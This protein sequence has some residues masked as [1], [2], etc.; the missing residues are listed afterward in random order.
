MN[1]RVR[2]GC[3]PS[4]SQSCPP[5]DTAST[6]RRCCGS[7]STMS[8]WASIWT[9]PSALAPIA[10]DMPDPRAPSTFT[11]TSQVTGGDPMS[12]DEGGH[13][14][15][16]ALS[17]KESNMP[18]SLTGILFVDASATSATQD[19][20]LDN[21]YQSIQAA[22]NAVPV[23]A[24]VADSIKEWMTLIAPGDY[25]EDVTITG[26]VRLALIGL[27]AFRLGR[28]TVAGDPQTNIVAVAGSE[29]RNLVW[30]YDN[31]QVIRDGAAPQLVVGTIGGT[32]VVRPGKPIANRI[33]G[34]II[35]Q[36]TALGTARGGTA[37]LSIA[38][39]QI[40]A[41]DP[42]RSAIAEEGDRSDAA[43]N[44][45]DGLQRSLGRQTFQLSL[46]RRNPWLPDR[47][48]SNGSGVHAGHVLQVSVRAA[49]SSVS[50]RQ[51][52]AGRN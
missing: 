40:D 44:R 49:G 2:C 45:R 16:L 22:V 9:M 47:Y 46:P 17:P 6:A 27:G 35:V 10:R 51:H 25:D 38:N 36:G 52:R 50:V 41:R 7:V 43:R 4:L 24:T 29:P 30:R 19:G 23:P 12:D 34:S 21:P 48:A 42:T 26:P 31:G 39:T 8:P 11:E 18:P 5:N 14:D 3:P 15:L 1:G 37:F 13:C 32:D 33:S 28:Y 20:S